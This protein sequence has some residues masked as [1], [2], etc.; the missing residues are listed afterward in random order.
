MFDRCTQAARSAILLARYQAIRLGA[1][2]IEP[3][4]L[5]LGLL[6]SDPRLIKRFLPDTA[7]VAAHLL[8]TQIQNSLPKKSSPS[9][10]I[11]LPFSS[12]AKTVLFNAQ[13]AADKYLDKHIGVEHLLLGLLQLTES[14][15]KQVL[16]TSG[17]T[18]ERVHAVLQARRLR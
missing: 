5:A 16:T 12:Q 10:T 15:S 4:H 6:R 9:A 11:E 1:V 3:D 2:C 17:L 7:A 13:A 14:P 18:S 8:F